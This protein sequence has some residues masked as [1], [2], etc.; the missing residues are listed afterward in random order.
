ME[1]Q[2]GLILFAFAPPATRLIS[3]YRTVQA[4]SK[5]RVKLLVAAPYT[6]SMVILIGV[7]AVGT[8]M[9]GGGIHF[10]STF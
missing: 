7:Q 5:L 2:L 1:V 6:D 9:L 3:F 8:C 4:W 10:I